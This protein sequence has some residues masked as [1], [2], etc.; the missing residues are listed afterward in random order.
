MAARNEFELGGYDA[1][2]QLTFAGFDSLQALAPTACR[3]FDATRNGLTLGEGAAVLNLETLASAQNRGAQIIGEII[4][5]G[6]TTDVHHLTQPHPEGDAALTAMRRHA[7]AG[8]G[9][10]ANQVDYVNAHGTRLRRRTMPPKPLPSIVGRANM[11]K[12]FRSVPPR[13]ASDICSARRARS[14][15][16]FA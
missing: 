15:R 12:I 6:A 9:V 7:C 4:G 13:R 3:P 8:N 10:T 1:L 16:Q 2:C 11:P 5:Y 14:K